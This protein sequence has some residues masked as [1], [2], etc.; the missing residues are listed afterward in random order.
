MQY[1]YV[2]ENI[3]VADRTASQN[4]GDLSHSG[5]SDFDIVWYPAP[6]AF[7]GS[8][9]YYYLLDS[10]EAN[11]CSLSP[12]FED[13]S[14]MTYDDASDYLEG[15]TQ[16]EIAT[17]VRL[18]GIG[19]AHQFIVGMPD[20]DL[21]TLTMSPFAAGG[22]FEFST[23]ALNGSISAA[24]LYLPT[25]L[26][27]ETLLG[28]APGVYDLADMHTALLDTINTHLEKFPR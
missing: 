23:Q 11:V 3:S 17:G 21:V 2:V 27:M 12:I 26:A 8:E 20:A 1:W 7:D 24:L 18:R 25:T 28:V 6:Y 19:K 13:Y 10:I 15:W 14:V 9:A 22:L 4:A 16:N 5:A